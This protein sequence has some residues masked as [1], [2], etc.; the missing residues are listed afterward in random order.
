MPPS[1][2]RIF[3]VHYLSAKSVETRQK[4]FDQIV[5]RLNENKKL[6]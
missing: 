6:M 2:K 1:T 3:A 4:R 5:G